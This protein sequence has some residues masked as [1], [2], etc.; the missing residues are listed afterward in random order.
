VAAGGQRA[1]DHGPGRR[2]RLVR[3]GEGAG[4]LVVLELARDAVGTE[5]EAF[6]GEDRPN[7]EVG[8]DRVGGL[9]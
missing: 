1:V 9:R 5:Q 2:R 8:A 4:D 6:V 7:P 3:S